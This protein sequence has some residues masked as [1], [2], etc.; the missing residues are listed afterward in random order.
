MGWMGSGG[1][2]LHLLVLEVP[3]HMSIDV[4]FVC[5]VFVVSQ[6]RKECIF[7]KP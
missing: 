3:V 5:E 2:G 4:T 7:C 6:K 1:I